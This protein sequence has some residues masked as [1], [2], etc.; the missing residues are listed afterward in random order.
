MP[1]IEP[2]SR[3]DANEEQRRVGDPIFKERG[4]DYD[5]PFGVLLHYPELAE[6]AYQ[7]GTFLRAGATLT[8]ALV[9]DVRF[10]GP[11]RRVVLT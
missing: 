9:T 10:V 5:G 4:H 2:L 1:K 3:E 6:R 8:E 7:Y 11:L